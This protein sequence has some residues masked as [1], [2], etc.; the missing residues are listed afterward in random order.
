MRFTDRVPGTGKAGMVRI[1]NA[2]ISGDQITGILE[3][4]DE[5][6][7]QGTLLNADVL[8]QMEE[9]IKAYVDNAVSSN[10]NSNPDYLPVAGGHMLGSINMMANDVEFQGSDSGGIVWYDANRSETDRIWASNDSNRSALNYRRSGS[11][12]GVIMFTSNTSASKI[13]FMIRESDMK[14][15]EIVVVNASDFGLNKIVGI[16]AMTR[17]TQVSGFPGVLVTWKN[18]DT[19]WN[20]AC[21]RDTCNG[22]YAIAWGN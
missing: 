12:S 4:A 16:V 22:F 9:D 7:V 3:H 14:G 5:A 8:N 15:D 13:G 6:T 18:S 1:K 17:R 20:I 19:N 21:D 10:N 11:N 2:V